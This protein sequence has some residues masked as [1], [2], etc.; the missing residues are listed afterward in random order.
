MSFRDYQKKIISKVDEKWNKKTGNKLLIEMPTGTGKTMVASYITSKLMTGNIIWIAHETILINQLEPAVRQNYERLKIKYPG[1]ITFMTR[2]GLARKIKEI[3][4]KHY[5]L[6]VCDEVH[7][8]T[9]GNADHDEY[10]SILK[11]GCYKNLLMLSATPWNLD[12]GLISEDDLKNHKIAYKM[13]EAIKEGAMHPVEFKRIDTG[14]QSILRDIA[15]EKDIEVSADSVDEAKGMYSDFGVKVLSESDREKFI[16]SHVSA[17]LDVFLSEEVKVVNGKKKIPPTIIYCNSVETG[18]DSVKSVEKLLSKNLSKMKVDALFQ[19]VS[20]QN[21][22]SEVRDIIKNFSEGS[23]DD[24]IDI[25]LVCDMC[26]AG[27]DYPGLECIVDFGLNAVNARDT[28]QKIGRLVRKADK[29]VS[30]FYYS[31]SLHKYIPI[32]GVRKELTP[33]TI[34]LMGIENK[35]SRDRDVASGTLMDVA[36]VMLNSGEV[37]ASEGFNV[38][39]GGVKES[40]T[41]DKETAGLLDKI[42]AGKTA[43]KTRSLV[44]TVG[45]IVTKVVEKGKLNFNFKLSDSFRTVD[46]FPD[47]DGN[48]KKIKTF[49]YKKGRLP[50]LANKNKEERRLAYLVNN[51]CAIGQKKGCPDSEFLKWAISVGYK[52]GVNKKEETI[53]EFKKTATDLGRFPNKS[54]FK[55]WNNISS[56]LSPKSKNY[57]DDFRNWCIKNGYKTK[58]EIIDSSK[59]KVISDIKKFYKTNNR[60][61]SSSHGHEEKLLAAQ[62]HRRASKDDQ[63]KELI[64]GFGE[65]IRGKP[66]WNKEVLL[67]FIKKNKRLPHYKKDKKYYDV[68]NSYVRQSSISYDSGFDKLTMELK[69][70]LDQNKRKK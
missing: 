15:K 66:E 60:L 53:K 7:A 16:N 4:K 6:L 48:K 61:P 18:A 20:G 36:G 30:R 33:G 63:F 25:L 31:R 12:K 56:Y 29:P 47:P 65:I 55:K 42:G 51:Y 49:Y 13:T 43:K 39:V 58:G 19:S 5:D 17:V 11:S 35:S 52:K 1:N 32:A 41:V 24:K 59:E 64:I 23:G 70:R 10:E 40:V 2:Q 14:I 68:F 21:S 27:F 50:S 57:C 37:G 69:T 8:G 9:A 62:M 44:S 54:E 38:S 45:F 34:S 26:R 67:A 22:K 46:G 3:P 28:M